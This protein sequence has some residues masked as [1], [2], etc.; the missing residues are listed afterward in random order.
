MLIFVLV[1]DLIEVISI[2][3]LVFDLDCGNYFSFLFLV[4]CSFF[5]VIVKIIFGLVPQL[6]FFA[7]IVIGKTISYNASL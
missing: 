3:V 5:I 7:F 4:F 2:F 1:F 6:L